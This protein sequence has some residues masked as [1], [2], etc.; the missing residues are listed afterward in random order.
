MAAKS[1]SNHFNIQNLNFN[2]NNASNESNKLTREV[3][4][5]YLRERNDHTVIIFNAKVAQKSY[6]NEKR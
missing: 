2:Q 5:K 6:G 1:S 4:R 3:M